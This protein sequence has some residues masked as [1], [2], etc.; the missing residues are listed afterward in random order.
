VAGV[1][2]TRDDTAGLIAEGLED[3]RPEC[4]SA[5]EFD[6]RSTEDWARS[7]ALGGHVPLWAG[8]EGIADSN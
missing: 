6:E 2:D 4:V 1:G 7:D 3:G 5:P 8:V